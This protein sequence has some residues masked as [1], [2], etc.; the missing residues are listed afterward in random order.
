M[1]FEA[2]GMQCWLQNFLFNY[3][4]VNAVFHSMA[5]LKYIKQAVPVI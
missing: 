2:Q 1:V 5:P 3:D 4:K